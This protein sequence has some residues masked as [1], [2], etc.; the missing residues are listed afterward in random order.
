MNTT[1]SLQ[2]A[3]IVLDVCRHTLGV[4]TPP[5]RMGEGRRENEEKEEE[6]RNEGNSKLR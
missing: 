1:L 3:Q 4:V 5:R 6:S 2:A